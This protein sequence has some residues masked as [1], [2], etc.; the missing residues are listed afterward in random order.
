M[1]PPQASAICGLTKTVVEARPSRTWP[2]T[3]PACCGVKETCRRCATGVAGGLDQEA[4]DAGNAVGV[5]STPGKLETV[6]NSEEPAVP[7]YSS[8]RKMSSLFSVWLEMIST[9]AVIAEPVRV[10]SMSN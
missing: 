7:R 9:V 5:A 1:R 8:Q 3:L 4:E 10:F 2:R 6:E